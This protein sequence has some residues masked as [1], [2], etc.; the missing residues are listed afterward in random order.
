MSV[1]RLLYYVK[2]DF[3]PVAIKRATPS[4]LE[5]AD[6]RHIDL[7]VIIYATGF[8]TSR[9]CNFPVIGHNAVHLNEKHNAHPRTYLSVTV[10]GLQTS[11]NLECWLDHAVAA[12][13]K[14]L[15]ISIRI[16]RCV[17]ASVNG[18]E[19][20]PS[21]RAPTTVFS[22][23]CRSWHKADKEGRVVSLWPGSP[24]HAAHALAH[25]LW[26]DY[27]FELLDVKNWSY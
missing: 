11:S 24:L 27:N 25:P 14:L 15:M 4:G 20:L 19:H 10:D 26:E 22:E 5:T 13:L 3:E 1:L 9:R 2:V 7:N 6:G 17:S 8:D 18:G 16:S 12:T 23:K 21:P